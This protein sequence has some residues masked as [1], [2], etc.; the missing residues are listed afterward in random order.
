MRKDSP[1]YNQSIKVLQSSTLF[2]G[3]EEGM[4]ENILEN[5]TPITFP[6]KTII[7]Y[8]ATQEFIFIILKG[9]VKLSKINPENGREFIV[10]ILN[11]GDVFDIISFLEEK[12]HEINIES[13][14][15]IELLKTSVVTARNWLNNNP[16]FNRNFLPY[17][18]KTMHSLE[19]SASD[20][21]LYDTITRLAKLILKN[22]DIND[23]KNDNFSVKL[24]NDLSHEALS[25]M[26]G[27]VRKVVNLNIQVLKK[28]GIITSVRGS[29]SVKNLQKLLDICDSAT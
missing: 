24:I 23:K 6:K 18:G 14:D 19:D 25:Q 22:T 16:N 5:F 13:I 1:Y 3:I 28:E 4:I 17:L 15:E 7:D 27:S 2:Y 10:S 29:L 12:E 21:A 11:K 20:L 26:I 8:S 9:R